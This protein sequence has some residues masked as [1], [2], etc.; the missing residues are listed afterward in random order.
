MVYNLNEGYGNVRKQRNSLGLSVVK[1]PLRGE[2]IC[3]P[4]NVSGQHMRYGKFM[5]KETFFSEER[6]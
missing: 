6:N 4:F 3:E 5:L 1:G 2:G